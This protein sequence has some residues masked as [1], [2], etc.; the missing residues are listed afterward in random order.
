MSA[1]AT[2]DPRD[3]RTFV[4]V[5][6]PAEV[7][8]A[9]AA[10]Q[11]RVQAA[12]A[13]QGIASTLRWSPVDN[14]HL[15]LRFLGDTT[16]AQQRRLIDGLASAAR[17]WSPF[18]LSTGGLGCF[19]NCR[20]PRVVWLGVAGDMA[21]LAAIQSEVERLAQAIGF[22]AEERAF[23]PHLTLARARREAS[24]PALQET[25]RV[26]AVLAV[27]DTPP[28][29]PFNVDHVVYFH[30][31]LRAGGSVYTPLAVLPF[32]RGPTT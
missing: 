18:A 28:A 19:P 14:I 30:S 9:I 29:L 24:R 11:A 6:L 5:E 4:A 7:K 3:R 10:E 12:L 27:D 25:G 26:L 21:A 20:A 17:V 1:A 23:S 15:T 32:G 31:D 8:R 16:S 22:A 2:T 13:G